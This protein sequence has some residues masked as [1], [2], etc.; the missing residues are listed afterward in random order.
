MDSNIPLPFVATNFNKS[1]GERLFHHLFLS[2]NTTTGKSCLPLL[3][4]SAASTSD[5]SSHVTLY[6]SVYHSSVALLANSDQL[7]LMSPV[8]L[9]GILKS[10][11]GYSK[12]ASDSTTRDTKTF[13]FQAI[14]LLAQRMP[15]LFRDK[16]D[17]AIRLFDALKLEASSLRFVVQE[18][19][20]LLAAAYKEA[21]T[22]VLNE[23]ETLL[24]KNSQ[25]EEGEVRFC[26]VRWATKLFHLQHCPSRFIC[27]L[28]AADSKL[29]IRLPD[30]LRLEELAI[31]ND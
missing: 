25:E 24:L 8:I 20:N 1:L 11:D 14:G 6:C 13:A 15:Q 12:S 17:M 7:K 23:L 3:N 2:K 9:N 21:P 4:L 22:T 10:L 18:A 19:T 5:F 28:A 27:M 30:T 29:D 31:T 16:I 26:A